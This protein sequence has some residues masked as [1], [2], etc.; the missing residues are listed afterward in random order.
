MF[1]PFP[2]ATVLV[3]SGPDHDP[4]RKHLFVLL[5]HGLGEQ[6]EVLLVS[7]SSIV[8]GVPHDPSCVLQPGDHPFVKRPTSIRY[9]KPRYLPRKS[10]LAAVKQGVF[11]PHDPVSDQLYDR[12]CAG[13]LAS[14]FAAPKDKSFLRWHQDLAE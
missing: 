12:I 1:L 3:A 4:D 7:L 13:L 6:E 10:L 14:A 9:D 5:T 2:K 11:V 8:N